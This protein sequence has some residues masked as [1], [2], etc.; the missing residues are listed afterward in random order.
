MKARPSRREVL[1]GAG[2]LAAAGA[3]FAVAGCSDPS[4]K[5]SVRSTTP[6]SDVVPFY[7]PNQAGI[8]TPPQPRLFFASLDLLTDDPK[9]LQTLLQRWSIAAPLLAAGKSVGPIEPTNRAAAPDDT[10]EAYELPP[11]KLTITVGLGRSVFVDPRGRDRLGLAHLLPP[12]LVPI[13]AFQ[14]GELLDPA[15]SDGDIALQCCADDATVAFHAFRNLARIGRDITT[16]RWTQLGFGRAASTG[17]Q[18]TPRNLQGFKDG[19]NNLYA[20]DDALMRRHVWVGPD[21]G[22]AWMTNGTYMVTRRIRM[23]LEHWDRSSL[24]D[25]EVT[26]GRTKLT[27]APLGGTAEPDVPALSAKGPDGE[28]VIAKDAHIRLAAPAENGGLRILRRGYN[29]SDGIEPNTGE[30]DAGLFFIAMQ[31]DPRQQFI[32]L[33]KRLGEVDALNEY[34]VHESGA[35]F[36]V[37]PGIEPDNTYA[38]HLF[39]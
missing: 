37:V 17:V 22:P 23:R 26:I 9:A 12:A 29:F 11:S 31:R 19:T 24:D 32:P 4:S 1:G 21:D 10:G 8:V 20:T 15:R 38:S 7:G 34:I 39:T 30:L 3:A 25:Q 35:L 27:G 36:A 13:P 6:E 2:V 16:V 5:S 33:Q 28:L 18:T 14:G